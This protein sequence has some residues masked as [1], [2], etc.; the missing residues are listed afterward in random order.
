M[1]H[2]NGGVS[3]IA[4]T[5]AID[6]IESGPVLWDSWERVFRAAHG[7]KDVIAMDIGG[8]TAKVSILADGNPIYRKPSDLFGIPVELSLPYLRSI[9]LGGG[10]VVKPLPGAGH[11]PDSNSGPKAW[12]V[13]GPAC[14]GLGG[15]QPTLTDAFV[16][17]GSDQSGIFSGGRETPRPRT[18]RNP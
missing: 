17:A 5:K 14:Y 1:S 6:T 2:I 9:A 4:K 12:I 11:R 16:T 3:G 13:P 8:T 7:L 15:D 18:G 10:S